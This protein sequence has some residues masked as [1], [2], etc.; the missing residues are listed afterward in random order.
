MSIAS[1]STEQPASIR[2][3]KVDSGG[4]MAVLTII[5]VSHALPDR[6]AYWPARERRAY[7]TEGDTVT[8][9][10]DA[11]GDGPSFDFTAGLRSQEWLV[12]L[13]MP[14]KVA[15][16]SLAASPDTSGSLSM[17]DMGYVDRALH[18]CDTTPEGRFAELDT[19]IENLEGACNP[20]DSAALRSALA[21]LPTSRCTLDEAE[22]AKWAHDVGR[23]AGELPG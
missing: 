10:S 14:F 19:L 23:D 22:L 21:R 11:A 20:P 3:Y 13:E 17:F 2:V 9:R 4:A 6:V 12:D 16:L 5:G 8:F 7:R 1:R 15:G 18:S